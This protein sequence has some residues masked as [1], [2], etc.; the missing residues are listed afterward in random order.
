MVM[1]IPYFFILFFTGVT[2]AA[3]DLSIKNIPAE[4]IKE[5]NLIKRHETRELIIKSPKEVLIRHKYA[6][7]I[8]NEKAD[9]YAEFTA[10]YDKFHS[11]IDIEGRLIDASGKEL[12]KVKK[13]DISDKS[14]QNGMSVS[15]DR[16]KVHS[17]DYKDYPYTVEY[18]AVYEMNGMFW[19]PGWVPQQSPSMGVQQSGMTVRTPK[20]YNL[21]FKE[22][23]FSGKANISESAT[24]KVFE[25]K[26]EN[27]KSVKLEMLMPHWSRERIYVALAPVQFEIEGV[28][29]T[30]NTWQEFGSFIYK[31]TQNRD[32][33]PEEVGKKARQMVAGVNDPLKKIEILYS[34]LQSHTRYISIQLGIGGWQPIPAAKVAQSGYGDCKA[35][36]NYMSA[37]LN[38]VNIDSKYVLINSEDDGLYTDAGFV[39]NQFD[40]AILCVPLK[41]DTVWLECTSQTL[42]AGYLGDHTYNRPALLIDQRGG[43]LVRTPSYAK[44]EN[45]QIRNIE[46]V[47][48][49]AGNLKAKVLSRYTGLQQDDLDQLVKTSPRDDVMKVLHRRFDLPTYDVIDFRYEAKPARVPELMEHLDLLVTGYAQVSGKRVFISPNILTKSGIKLKDDST[50]RF[51]IELDYDYFDTDTVHIKIPEGYEIESLPKPQQIKTKFGEYSSYC[52]F[53]NNILAYSRSIEQNSGRYPA[54]DYREIASFLQAV[55]KADRARVVLKKKEQP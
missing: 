26:V 39:S 2:L 13:K 9:D 15:D 51:D 14:T 25:W 21:R 28:S 5:S 8:L 43:T 52:S 42:P 24:E 11:I 34:Y 12:K 35:L 19:L 4:L 23:N 53:Q 36:T 33:V 49:D 41:N 46:A 22:Y 47:L 27:L 6:Y 40:H 50:R 7:T 48:D 16:Y 18:T 38:E 17:F 37:L 54:S 1:R 55:H 30:M 31:L 44:K 29:G 3:Q 10:Y 45:L 20:G 32:A